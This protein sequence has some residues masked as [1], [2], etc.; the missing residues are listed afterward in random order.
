MTLIADRFDNGHHAY[1]F[2]ADTI[3]HTLT[4]FRANGWVVDGTLR[5][6]HF[7]DSR[8]HVYLHGPDATDRIALVF[9][10]A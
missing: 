7:H 6:R 3:A 10:F 4:R 1:S 9:R 5:T 8:Y 2:T